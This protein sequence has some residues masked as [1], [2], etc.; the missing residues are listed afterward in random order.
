VA[1]SGEHHVFEKM[2]K[3]GATCYL[4]LGSHVIPNIDSNSRRS[5][6]D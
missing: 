4:I 1:G 5:F 3:T 2:R 6:I